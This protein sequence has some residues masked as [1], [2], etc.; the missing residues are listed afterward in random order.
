VCCEGV[1][2]RSRITVVERQHGGRHCPLPAV[3]HR[4]CAYTECFQWKLR[5]W[6]PCQTEAC[7]FIVSFSLCL[8]WCSPWDQGLGLEPPRGQKGF[9]LG[10]EKSLV[11]IT[12]SLLNHTTWDERQVAKAA[13]KIVWLAFR[14]ALWTTL[15]G[16]VDVWFSVVDYLNASGTLVD[17]M[18]ACYN[19]KMHWKLKLQHVLTWHLIVTWC[20]IS[21]RHRWS[22]SIVK[23]NC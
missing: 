22:R 5:H 1:Q 8:R 15:R 2:T 9:G 13:E 18:K 10:L 23:R 21:V 20:P 11:F 16:R 19:V 6:K 3:Q 14:G 12:V 7:L 4:Y 17:I